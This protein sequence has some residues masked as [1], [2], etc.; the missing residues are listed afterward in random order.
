[1]V[2]PLRSCRILLAASL[3]LLLVLTAACSVN[4]D[5]LGSWQLIH[6]GG[7]RFDPQTRFEFLEDRQLL[8]SPQASGVTLTYS[9]GPGGDLSITTKQTGAESFTVK[10]KYELEGDRLAI[11]DEDGITLLFQRMAAPAP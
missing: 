11:T 6:D 5:L 9:T 2:Q 8:L 10:M 7:T 3:I 4:Q 1:M